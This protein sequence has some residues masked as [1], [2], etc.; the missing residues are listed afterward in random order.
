VISVGGLPGR[1][2]NFLQEVRVLNTMS[3]QAVS[4]LFL[5]DEDIFMTIVA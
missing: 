4:K 2:I 3:T 5:L 1:S